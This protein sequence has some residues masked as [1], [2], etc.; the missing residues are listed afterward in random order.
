MWWGIAFTLAA[1][2]CAVLWVA[3]N[4]TMSGGRRRHGDKRQAPPVSGTGGDGWKFRP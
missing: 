1:V 2:V 4:V 3:L